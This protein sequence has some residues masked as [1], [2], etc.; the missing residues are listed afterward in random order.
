MVSCCQPAVLLFYSGDNNADSVLPANSSALEKTEKW[1]RAGSKED[2]EKKAR[3]GKL[4]DDVAHQWVK[5]ERDYCWDT[6]KFT[7]NHKAV[8]SSGGLCV[9]GVWL[10]L[11]RK[12]SVDLLS[13]KFHGTDTVCVCV[14]VWVFGAAVC[15]C[16]SDHQKAGNLLRRC[17]LRG[18]AVC[19]PPSI[20]SAPPDSESQVSSLL[21]TLLCIALKKHTQEM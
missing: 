2:R 9:S 1:G 5:W 18:R 21:S 15:A 14:S 7:E 16:F 4:W 19:S 3:K 8:R 12:V 11:S 10:W 20:H 17:A 13:L 6:Q